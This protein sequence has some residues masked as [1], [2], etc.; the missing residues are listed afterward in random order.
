MISKKMVKALTDQINAELYSGY[1]YMAMSSCCADMGLKG[2]SHWFFVQMQEE[3]THAFRFYKYMTDQGEHC[4]MQAIEKPQSTFKSL[5]A[6]FE[7]TLEHEKL[8]TSLINKL[9]DLARKESDH[10]SDVMLGWFVSEQVEEE[11]TASEIL[12]TLTLAAT[13]TSAVLMI[14]R[15]LGARVFTPPTDIVIG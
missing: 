12:Q 3:M 13:D 14:D 2:A 10:A 5:K 1:L 15:E 4:V 7:K 11:A 6:M 9:V 8:V